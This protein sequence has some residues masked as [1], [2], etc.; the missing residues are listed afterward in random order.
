[1]KVFAKNNPTRSSV[2]ST[3]NGSR[4]YFGIQAKLAIGKSNDKYEK[5]ADASADKVVAK[6]KNDLHFFGNS[7]FFPPAHKNSIQKVSEEEN[8]TD[9]ATVQEKPLAKTLTPV[10]Q[11]K[12][13][14][15]IQE[16][17]AEC[18]TKKSEEQ[19]LQKVS[20]EEQ[21][22]KK[23]ETCEAE[24][25]GKEK[26]HLN[27]I[28][29]LPFEEVQ[30]ASKKDD[31]DEDISAQKRKQ[32][33]HI[34]E[35]KNIS[36]NQNS[37]GLQIQNKATTEE[38]VQTFRG[39][40]KHTAS[41]EN[42]LHT[43]RGRGAP[44][45]SKTKME[46]ESGFG[47]DF[48][49]VRI[50]N[51]KNAIQMSKQLRAQAFTTGNDIFFN[52]GK[53]QPE[54]DA[55][56]HLLAHEL[57]HTIQQGASKPKERNDALKTED[58]KALNSKNETKNTGNTVSDLARE[59]DNN[60]EVTAKV[61][62]EK[63][64]KLAETKDKEESQVEEGEVKKE[65][66]PVAKT[67][68]PR[69]P[70]EDSNFKKLETRVASTAKA[71]GDHEDSEVSANKAQDA[72]VSPSNERESI[73][74]TGQ[75]NAMAE[76]EPGTF[77]SEGFKAKLMERIEAMQLPANQDE[78]ANFEDNNNIDEV[79]EA[80]ATD[81]A[82]EKTAATGSVAQTTAQEPNTAAVPERDVTPLPNAPVGK[83]PVTINPSTAMP[84]KRGRAEVDKPL[85]DNLS[86]V[87]QQMAENEVTEDQLAKSN[88][89]S[90]M[91]GL[92]AKAKAKSNTES[93]PVQLRQQETS[94]LQ[95]AK[96]G[97]KGK[98]EKGLA[99]MHQ[100]RGSLL[101][102]VNN[103][104]TKTGLSHTAERAHIASE[105]N[106]IYEKSKTDVEKILNDL[107]SNVKTAF[108]SG[109]S[110]AKKKFEKHV[111]D[112]MRAYKARRY[113]DALGGARWLKDA[114]VGMP[115]EVNDFFVTGREVYISTMDKVIT[116]VAEYVATKL[117]EAKARVHKGKQ[118][119]SNYVESLPKELQKLGKQ[120]AENINDKFNEL[121]SSVANKQDELIDS[122]AEQYMEGLN[123]VDA[124]IE[125]MKAANRGLVDAALGFI[126][127]II[128]TIKKLKELITTLLAEIQ[129]ALGVIM[130]DPIGFATNLFEGVRK[131]IDM[132]MANI[133]KHVLGGFVTWLT[134]ALG[135]MGITIPDNLFSLKGIFSL[136]MQVL[137]LTWEYMR[138]KSIMLLGEPMV[139][140]MEKGFAMFQTI[141]EKGISGIWEYLKDQ[142]T[143]LKETIIESI[144]SMLI[145][146]VLEAGIKWL[147]SLL[148]PGAGFIKAIIAIKDFIVFFVQSAIALIPSL[149][150][151]IKSLASGSIKGVSKA[152][153]KGLAMLVPFVIGL[154]AK[155]LGLGGIVKKVQKIIKKVRKRIDRAITK[156]I[157]KAKKKFKSLVKK[158]KAKVKSG[159]A[160][161]IK[162]WKA[163]KKFKDKDGKNHTLYFKGQGKSSKLM[164]ASN[165]KS[166][167]NFIKGLKV[168]KGNQLLLDVKIQAKV[169]AQEVDKEV[170]RSLKGNNDIQK[171][172]DRK[173]KKEKIEFLL[174]QLAPLTSQLFGI[175]ENE[176]LPKS[177]ITYKGL[178]SYGYATR[179]EGLILTRNGE[180]GGP[181]PSYPS[182][183]NPLYR[184][185][186]MRKYR[187]GT[188][189]SYVRGHMINEF[190]HGPGKIKNFTP[191][192]TIG[193]KN[194][195]LAA[196]T[197][198][199]KA[200]KSGGVVS[201]AVTAVYGRSKINSK[202][203]AK[204]FDDAKIA[205]GD[206]AKI[207]K[208]R[209][210]EN[211]VPKRL[212]LSSFL[213]KKNPKNEK[214]WI[215][216][217]PLVESKKI[218]NPILIDLNTYA[219][220]GGSQETS[221]MLFLKSS[222]I[223][224]LTSLTGI[225]TE[226]MTVIQSAANL[227]MEPIRNVKVLKNNINEAV[228]Y[229]DSL[230]LIY[231]AG[232]DK[233]SEIGASKIK[234]NK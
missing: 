61:E 40:S 209:E 23:C 50:H 221:N 226:I 49:G 139:A 146:Q 133:Q 71:Q 32:N 45:S 158:G 216:D 184:I 46:M 59:D 182:E 166:Y 86:E 18:G 115:D 119:V 188:G 5:E 54:S 127:G 144:K 112:K 155:L 66:S 24:E 29:K 37:R 179:V 194:H 64:E 175:A 157:K 124:R 132:F 13:E 99:G 190:L 167:F 143:D 12:T 231:H 78:A 165:P 68:T 125:E 140:A 60:K 183:S 227:H 70:K 168:P 186:N 113:G 55:G 31:Q 19:R 202:I 116:K 163:K 96:A 6:S 39:K 201:Y 212:N 173:M 53:L 101:N 161:V 102:Q 35:V 17:C 28:Q 121:E 47:A 91:Q 44:L 67:T 108:A 229:K 233:I 77:N 92:D 211:T 176:E 208:I 196:E 26:Q 162:W 30:K 27:N 16:K 22:Q 213:L 117:T 160:S 82:G 90:F 57:T 43:S 58:E 63:T 199:K 10:V 228:G 1:M 65:E 114:F 56:K 107:D 169:K 20:E 149:I 51:G 171:D 174:S 48:S 36:N 74:Q 185:L 181:P 210:A 189:T 130:E 159:I 80:A 111:D 206:R 15:E 223:G 204:Q 198:V 218:E 150:D 120:A 164:V 178:N 41:I 195:L 170:S 126:N 75:V 141:R 8:K 205:E 220:K 100:A 142:F 225:T 33:A 42:L 129:N 85:Q 106:S 131:G 200:V 52:E 72:A 232:I 25:K 191:L 98:E 103:S 224:D 147:L 193:N 134:G 2:G 89:P 230:K 104:Q 83:K 14:E 9:V 11:L 109:T 93:A 177:I 97:A 152:I 34:S 215:K 4:T 145:T 207:I 192:S 84:P 105:I 217:K 180:G 222:S 21:I 76:A 110:I 156:L 137:G 138:K 219:V 148:I 94:A 3:R 136:V 79:N 203:T 7:E 62:I 172:K 95:S 153:E 234:I 87:D 81:L 214:R 69:S 154:F 88:E 73:A 197:F 128:E 38:A 151:A 122:L 135:P 123:A 187:N 118:E